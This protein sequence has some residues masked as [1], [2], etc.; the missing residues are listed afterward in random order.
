MTSLFERIFKLREHGTTVRTEILAAL[1][2]FMTMSYILVVNPAVLSTTGMPKEALFTAT[3]LAAIV[4]CIL[5]GLIGNLPMAMATG[6]GANSFFAFTICGSMGFSWQFALTATLIEG[7][8][9]IIMTFFKIRELVVDTIPHN[10]KLSISTGIGMFIAFIGL[11]TAGIVVSGGAIVHM[12]NI[13][14]DPRI[15][16]ALIGLT[17]AVTLYA[18]KIRGAILISIIIGTIAGLFLTDPSTGGPITD[19]SAWSGAMSIFSLP[20]S[21]DPIFCQFVGFEQIFTPEMIVC[22]IALLLM[23]I[24]DTVGTLL[25]IATK[26]N[27]M[28][29]DGKI[30]RVTRALFADAV[31]TTVGAILGTATVT[32]YVES[33]TGVAAGGRTG[34]VPFLIGLMFVCCVFFSNIFLIVPRVATTP[35]LI[36]VG[37]FMWNAL[38]FGKMDMPE[39]VA[40][41]ITAIM[42]P[43]SYSIAEGIFYGI[44]SFTLF[45]LLAGKFSDLNWVLISLSI[46][47]LVKIWKIGY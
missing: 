47:L 31:A 13:A 9:F 3:V 19:L 28:T 14:G 25:S 44:L 33:T 5:M 23:E 20:P 27:L 29:K 36:I 11:K 6:M 32:T 15:W 10:I 16:V 41:F 7:I 46:L 2:V 4:G 35:A 18:W 21:L 26:A 38:D 1:T 8:I 24:F 40:C 42:M 43:L 30:L 34:M 39:A 37:V 22:V 45:K 12:G 17:T